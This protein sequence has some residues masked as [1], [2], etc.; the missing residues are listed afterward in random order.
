MGFLNKELQRVVSN[1]RNLPGLSRFLLP[2]HFSDLRFAASY[3]PVVIVNAS[4][5]SCDALVVLADGDSVHIPLLITKQD[6]RG[7]SSKLCTTRAEFVRATKDLGTVLWELWEQLVFPIFKFLQTK[8]PRQSR[9][10]WYPTAEFSLLPLHAAGPYRIGQQNF[11]DMYISSYTSTLSALICARG[12]SPPNLGTQVKWFHRWFHSLTPR[13]EHGIKKQFIAIGRPEA[14]DQKERLSMG[15]ELTNIGQCVSRL[16]TFT[17]IEGQ[18]ACI[19]R[20]T[21]ELSK[22]EWV[23]FACDGLL[24]E[25]QPFESAFVL[26]DGNLTIH[27]LIGCDLKNPEFAY[28][29]AGHGAV[30]SEESTDEGIHLASAMQFAGFR[31]VIGTMWTMGDEETNKTTSL[32]YKY[33]VDKSGCLDHACAAF[34]LWKTMESVK[35]PLDQRI[36]AVH[37]GA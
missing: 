22:N 28:L 33:M 26:S 19:S 11:A 1:I 21:E 29:S 4:K 7:L 23:H 25:K 37:I 5:Y 9:V 8:Y 2:P 6:V 20:V 16:A 32:I 27:R 12:L 36:A 15:T 31:S 17:R 10:W 13:M 3:G 18:G 34:A 35:I 24:N 14:R 30:G